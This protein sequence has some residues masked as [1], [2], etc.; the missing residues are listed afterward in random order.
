[1]IDVPIRP[2]CFEKH[3]GFLI[4]CRGFER[5]TAYSYPLSD[6]GL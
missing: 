3:L 5:K 1:M 6:L 4:L 2:K